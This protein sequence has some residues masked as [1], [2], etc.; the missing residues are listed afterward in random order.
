MKDIKCANCGSKEFITQANKYDVYK[1]IDN[2]LQLVN[3]E[4][5]DDENIFYCRECGELLIFE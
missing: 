4:N 3:T 1:V 2:E 5:I